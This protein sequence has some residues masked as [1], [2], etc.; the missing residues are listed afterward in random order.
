MK[1]KQKKRNTKN[2]RKTKIHKTRKTQKSFC[3]SNVSKTDKT[4]IF[5]QH[6]TSFDRKSKVPFVSNIDSLSV[7]TIEEVITY[8]KTQKVIES[9]CHSNSIMLSTLFPKFR[10][11][12]GYVGVKLTDTEFE[13]WT[14][15]LPKNTNNFIGINVEGYGIMF[16]DIKRKMK[17]FRHSWN[18]LNGIHFDITKSLK[19]QI[20]KKWWN[21]FPTEIIDLS[22][23]EETHLNRIFKLSSI[24]KNQ[25]VKEGCDIL[26][27][28]QLK[29]AS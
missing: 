22:K 9:G 13:L 15:Q 25:L 26:N 17:Y 7:C 6:L 8:I 16:F 1:T 11:V 20:V 24:H 2:F 18:E 3:W 21:Y 28:P 12:H 4:V 27:Y 14:N 5:G 10:T 23:V 19:K 29:L